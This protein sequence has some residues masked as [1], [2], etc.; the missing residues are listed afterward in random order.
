[1]T[2]T[3]PARTF[4]L[5]GDA[6]GLRLTIYAEGQHYPG[7]VQV[8]GR[9]SGSEWRR[10]ADD[11]GTGPYTL[12]SLRLNGRVYDGRL[13]EAMLDIKHMHDNAKGN[14]QVA[15]ADAL[16]VLEKIQPLDDGAPRTEAPA[17]HPPL[18]IGQVHLLSR[19]A[20]AIE[21]GRRV[22]FIPDGADDVVTGT[23]RHI[24]KPDSDG[25]LTDED[26][27]DGRVRIT[28]LTGS[29]VYLPVP[30]VLDRMARGEFGIRD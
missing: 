7:A 8:W 16:A 25:F 14:W 15:L 26:P 6:A 4:I 17:P 19:L 11:D 29:D 13:R 1:M 18:T 22:R 24:V 2:T 12:M 28:L 10:P 9:V 30:A 27:R 20:N 21:H 23:L 5:P 3:E